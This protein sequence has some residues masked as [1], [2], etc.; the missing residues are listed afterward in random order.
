MDSET[1]TGSG[2]VVGRRSSKGGKRR[3]RNPNLGYNDD[4]S[5]N[6][7]SDTSPTSGYTQNTATDDDSE[8]SSPSRTPRPRARNNKTSTRRRKASASPVMIE[9]IIEGFAI[10]SFRSVEDIEVCM[11]PGEVTVG[12]FRSRT[13]CFKLRKLVTKTISPRSNLCCNNV[14]V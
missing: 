11:S 9:D 14:L 8:G 5:N 2:A 10:A 1:S 7:L 4:R 3:E 6:V 12:E 13:L